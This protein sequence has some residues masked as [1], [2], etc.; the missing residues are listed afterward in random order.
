MVQKRFVRYRFLPSV[1]GV[2]FPRPYGPGP[3]R[4][5][6]SRTRVRCTIPSAS[7]LKKKKSFGIDKMTPNLARLTFPIFQP[8][9][10][11]YTRKMKTLRYEIENIL[12]A[13]TTPSCPDTRIVDSQPEPLLLLISPA[14]DLVSAPARLYPAHVILQG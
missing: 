1:V 14:T 10:S 6:P 9:F 11:I 12:D 4:L 5:Q 8:R 3:P 7:L 13:R 2:P